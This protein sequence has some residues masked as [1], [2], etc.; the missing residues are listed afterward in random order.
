[1]PGVSDPISDLGPLGDA[2]AFE[3]RLQEEPIE[4]PT[5]PWRPSSN[6]RT[7]DYEYEQGPAMTDY[8]QH[9]QNVPDS[10]T[11]DYNPSI[12]R[13]MLAGLA[14]GAAGGSGGAL[15]GIKAA[16]SIN[17]MPYRRAVED[18]ERKG[19]A[20]ESAARIEDATQKTRQAYQKQ[21][22]DQEDKDEDRKVKWA[23]SEISRLRAEQATKRITIDQEIRQATNQITRDRLEAQKK[24]WDD[25]S[26]NEIARLEI[27]KTNAGSSR[28]SA[29]ASAQ[30]A[31]TNAG[32]GAAYT[33]YMNRLGQ[34]KP[35]SPASQGITR[36]I[37]EE[38]LKN[39]H[40]EWLDPKTGAV[41]DTR[42]FEV[43]LQRR[44]RMRIPAFTSDR[45]LEPED[46]PYE[47]IQ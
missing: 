18:Y 10:S 1:M 35:M 20:L 40:P 39:E 34:P 36:R 12:W 21:I 29:N 15:Q 32:R 46:N 22:A 2:N 24:K 19:S 23:N 47:I 42:A 37:A 45:E 3:G 13:R 27:L 6:R 31:T 43:E 4:S 8:L 38:E 17:E 11:G 44:L 30:N 33:N 25:D 16:Q 9:I 5:Q 26:E 28:I 41:K 7:D 14:G